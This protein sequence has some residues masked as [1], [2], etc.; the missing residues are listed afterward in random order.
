MN[1]DV[2]RVVRIFY[3][4]S[5]VGYIVNF[6]RRVRTIEVVPATSRYRIYQR[7]AP[8]RCFSFE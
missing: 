5:R 4:G 8:T 6:L 7:F 2:F 3:F 1:P